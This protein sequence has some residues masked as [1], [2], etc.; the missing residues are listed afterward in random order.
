MPVQTIGY[1]VPEI[2]EM[3]TG[4]AT[5]D[6]LTKLIACGLDNKIRDTIS[7][8]LHRGNFVDYAFIKL[9]SD[10]GYFIAKHH[11]HLKTEDLNNLTWTYSHKLI[12]L[13]VDTPYMQERHL[14]LLHLEAAWHLS[15]SSSVSIEDLKE[16]AYI[17][18]RSLVRNRSQQLT[19]PGYAEVLEICLRTSPASFIGYSSRLEKLTPA[20]FWTLVR[21]SPVECYD[22]HPGRLDIEHLKYVFCKTQG[23]M[24]INATRA[25]LTDLIGQDNFKALLEFALDVAPE[26]LVRFIKKFDFTREERVRL[27]SKCGRRTS[28]VEFVASLSNL[29]EDFK[30]C[31]TAICV[32]NPEEAF[33]EFR[34]RMSPNQLS[35]CRSFLERE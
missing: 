35:L 11:E 20:Q 18:P 16:L 26:V 25:S 34:S 15:N 9:F 5:P 13:S 22:E 8:L 4:K 3:V 17:D 7:S 23:H 33:K 30:D 24:F 19:E 1:T 27:V 32:S 28:V 31:L 10:D 6:V 21:Y 12:Q 29:H 14:E 2:E